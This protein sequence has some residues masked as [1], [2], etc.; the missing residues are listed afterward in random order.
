MRKAVVVAVLM[1]IGAV[2]FIVQEL[3][4]YADAVMPND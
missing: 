2:L 3:G 4:R 1:M